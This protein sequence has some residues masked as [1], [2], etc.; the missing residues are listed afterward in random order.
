MVAALDPGGQALKRAL[1]LPRIERRVAPLPLTLELPASCERAERA[2]EINPARTVRRERAVLR[3]GAQGLEGLEVGVHGLEDSGT[4]V[5]ARARFAR[6]ETRT[7]VLRAGSP[8]W[9]I[10]TDDV[11]AKTSGDAATGGSGRE[12]LRLGVQHILAGVDHLLFVIT[13]V[14]LAWGRW[15]ALLLA[16]TAFTLAHSVTLAL[17]SLGLVRVVGAA[18]EAII[19]LSILLLAAELAREPGEERRAGAAR[20]PWVVAFVCGLVHGFGFAGAL[21]EIGL[22]DGAVWV[23]L[24]LFNLGVELGQLAFVAVIVLAG[25][26]INATGLASRARQL[27]GLAL[28]GIGGVAAYWL[29]E[30]LYAAFALG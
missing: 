3:C 9:R 5:I 27:R 20:A 7:R 14:A 21:A 23:A 19:A 13:L 29:L 8:R 25:A 30:R 24:L 11:T 1:V 4:E 6:G 28:H 15:R 10:A 26:L 18:V 22:P 17:T 16:I 12:Y 2:V